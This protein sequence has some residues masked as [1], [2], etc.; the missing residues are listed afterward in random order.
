MIDRGTVIDLKEFHCIWARTQEFYNNL[1][2]VRIPI[3]LGLLEI[4]S[5]IFYNLGIHSIQTAL[6]VVKIVPQTLN[7]RQEM[8]KDIQYQIESRLGI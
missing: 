6:K 8:T 7:V 4:P 3:K 5:Q 1:R 2:C